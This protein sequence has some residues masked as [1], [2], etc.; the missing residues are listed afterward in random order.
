LSK[1]D[2]GEDA[3]LPPPHLKVPVVLCKGLGGEGYYSF[4]A[5]VDLAATYYFI[6]QSTVDK[7]KL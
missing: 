3:T 7:L 1:D 6:S 5:L 4:S 2:T